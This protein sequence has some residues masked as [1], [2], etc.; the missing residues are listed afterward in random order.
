MATYTGFRVVSG[1]GVELLRRVDAL[2]A[3]SATAG[4]RVVVK[5]TGIAYEWN[6]SAWVS[7]GPAVDVTQVPDGGSTGQVLRKKSNA[8]AD[9]EWATVSGGGGGGSPNLDGGTASSIYGG[10][11]PIDGGTA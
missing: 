4:D 7:L 1:A 2:P 6:G 9:L 5:G 10:I 3:S 11:D 8:D